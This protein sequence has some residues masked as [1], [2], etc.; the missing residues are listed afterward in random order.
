MDLKDR[1]VALAES[2]RN[3]RA[4][5]RNDRM[6]QDLDH[7]RVENE[8][9][10]DEVHRDQERLMKLLGSIERQTAGRGS[11]PHRIRRFV[12]LTA[13]AGGAY[14]VGAKAG[15]E[16]YE[17]IRQRWLQLRDRDAVSDFR[18]AADQLVDRA[19]QTVETAAD[20]A[21]AAVQEAS[22]KATATIEEA[23]IPPT[24]NS[25]P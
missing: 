5:D 13:A 11:K 20:R 12:T 14:I 10:R 9:L 8:A 19:G 2:V 22:R 17:Q 7:L 6:E 15:R 23:R 1:T 18:D 21:S 24:K 3:R 25:F 4:E 16:R